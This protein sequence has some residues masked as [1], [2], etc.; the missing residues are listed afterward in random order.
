MEHVNVI[1]HILYHTPSAMDHGTCTLYKYVPGSMHENCAT[2][3]KLLSIV[4]IRFKPLFS[5]KL[6]LSSIQFYQP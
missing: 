2:V 5:Y 6:E 1:M 4:M 3:N